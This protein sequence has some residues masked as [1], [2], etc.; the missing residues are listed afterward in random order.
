ML[1]SSRGLGESL[2]ACLQPSDFELNQQLVSWLAALLAGT[3]QNKQALSDFAAL[4]AR[5]RSQQRCC[6]NAFGILPGEKQLTYGVRGRA[7]GE[8]G[9]LGREEERH[10]AKR[11]G[12]EPA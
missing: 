7:A 10:L 4:L 9:V 5:K 12:T 6:G 3:E 11:Y 8:P 2:Y 1:R